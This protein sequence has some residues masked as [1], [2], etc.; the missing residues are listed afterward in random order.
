MGDTFGAISKPVATGH[1]PVSDPAL[2]YL[3]EYLAAVLNTYAGDAW[4]EVAA[5]EPMV[6]SVFTHDPERHDF[7]E[8]DCPALFLWREESKPQRIADDIV[9]DEPTIHMLWIFAPATQHKDRDRKPIFAAFRSLVTGALEQGRDPAWIVTGDTDTNAAT[10]GSLIQLWAGL[11]RIN[12][13]SFKVA[14]LD[15]ELFDGGRIEPYDGILCDF[16]VEELRERDPSAGTWPAA[17][18]VSTKTTTDQ[19]TDL[20]LVEYQ[21]PLIP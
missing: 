18:T 7:N 14:E 6:R 9:A 10:R 21:D 12:P 16:R 17:I 11:S 5:T 8:R 13:P 2:R 4:T 1:D 3:G 19:D 20:D 15:V